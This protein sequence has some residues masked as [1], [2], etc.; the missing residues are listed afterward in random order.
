MRAEPFGASGVIAGRSPA[1]TLGERDALAQPRRV[2]MLGSPDD[3]NSKLS[4]CVLT[5]T[6]R[7]QPR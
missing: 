3:P 2:I 1:V 7:S 5:A 4:S 6:H